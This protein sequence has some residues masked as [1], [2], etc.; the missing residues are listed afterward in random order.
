M[1]PASRG[2]RPAVTSYEV[3]GPPRG[4]SAGTVALATLIMLLGLVA[5]GSCAELMVELFPG[6]LSSQSETL[7][8]FEAVQAIFAAAAGFLLARRAANGS[9]A[10]AGRAY[11]WVGAGPVALVLAVTLISAVGSGFPWWRVPFDSALVAVSVVLAC[12]LRTRH[13]HR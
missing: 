4:G 3:T 12:R 5:E 6:T 8:M 7:L 11:V 13:H 10:G 1:M 9:C 2:S